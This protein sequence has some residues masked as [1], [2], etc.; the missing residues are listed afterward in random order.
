MCIKKLRRTKY[1]G[2]AIVCL[3]ALGVAMPVR[4]Q[5]SS[6]DGAGQDAVDPANISTYIGMKL[7]E[8]I[9]AF[10]PPESVKVSRGQELWQDDVVFIYKD[11][12]FY[13]FKDRVWQI[14]IK[15]AFGVSVGDPKPAAVLAL[16]EEATDQGDYMLFTLP[17][18][19]WPL[20]LRLNF[21]AAGRVSAIFVYR[22]DF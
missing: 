12:E 3:L 6:S 22:P 16:G 20:M 2:F 1:S 7:N 4:S 14:G 11:R 15:N 21:N 10:G 17:P 18:S 9:T 5:T 8:L 13:I 19:G